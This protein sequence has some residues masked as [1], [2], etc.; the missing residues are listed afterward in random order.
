MKSVLAAAFRA[1]PKPLLRFGLFAANAKFIHGVVGV[2]QDERGRV[3]VLRHVFRKT[4]PWGFPSGL[5]NVGEDA[6]AAAA[7]ELHEETGLA[8]T[9]L[10]TGATT[11]VA[12][13]HLETVVYG[14]AD[15]AAEIRSSH[16]IF[17]ARWIDPAAPDADVAAELPQAHR[18][19]LD[20]FSN[21]GTPAPC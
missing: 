12:P 13:R 10:K 4:K 11:L 17:E 7:R 14:R 18:E 3:L 6:C 5:A 8:A 20:R 19:L 9:D 1:L 16:E 2:F 21:E 15:S